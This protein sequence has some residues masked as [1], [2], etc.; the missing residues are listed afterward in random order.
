MIDC[1]HDMVRCENINLQHPH[2]EATCDAT[3]WLTDR[4][5]ENNYFFD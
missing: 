5:N 2:R 4:S 1:V 3:H